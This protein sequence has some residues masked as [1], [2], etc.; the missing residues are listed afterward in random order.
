MFFDPIAQSYDEWYK[1]PLGRFADEVET[2]L[3]FRLFPVTKESLILDAG[4][5]TGNFSLKLARKGARVIG[6]DISTEMLSI[7]REKAKREG[8][9]IIFHQMDI[10]NLDFEDNYFDGIFSMAAFEFIKEPQRAFHELWRV[11]KPGGYL[12]IGTINRDSAWGELY[13]EQG[14]KADSVFYHA[15]FKTLAELED[16]DRRNLIDSGESLFIKPDTPEEKITLEEEER[17][18]A[19]EK[20]GFIA[21]LW[22]KTVI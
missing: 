8:L 22:Q 20:G 11:L 6:V 14:K 19:K 7:A 15:S 21:A 12:L 1:T 18:S 5:G 3:A 2:A 13:I 9:E 17:L 10:Y 4:C 16:L